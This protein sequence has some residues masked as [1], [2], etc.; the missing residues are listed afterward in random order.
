MLLKQEEWDIRRYSRKGFKLDRQTS[1]AFVILAGQNHMW[2]SV[3]TEGMLPEQ[4]CIN[5]QQHQQKQKPDGTQT[6]RG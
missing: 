5:K 4:I 1:G 3:F 6:G 2:S